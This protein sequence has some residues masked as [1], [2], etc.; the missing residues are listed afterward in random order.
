MIGKGA[1]NIS[2][3][4]LG[5]NAVSKIYLGEELVFG[6]GPQY[7]YVVHSAS[8]LIER[9]IAEPHFNLYSLVS[10]GYNYEGYS[11]SI[12]VDDNYAG[13]YALALKNGTFET[14]YPN[15]QWVDDKLQDI[16]FVAWDG[17]TLTAT[18]RDGT[19]TRHGTRTTYIS[20]ERA[21]D[22]TPV[23]GAVYYLI[24]DDASKY[25]KTLLAMFSASKDE[26][27]AYNAFGIFF[28]VST[29]IYQ[30]ITIKIDGV[31]ES[32]RLGSTFTITTRINGTQTNYQLKQ[33]NVGYR[34]YCLNN[35]SLVYGKGLYEQFA[36]YTNHAVKVVVTT[37]DGMEIVRY[38]AF[39][40]GDRTDGSLLW[41]TPVEYLESTGT[42]YIDLPMDVASGTFFEVDMTFI[43]KYTN[44][45]RYSVFSAKPYQQFEG[46]F[47][48]L[49]AQNAIT[50]ASTIGSK[51]TSGEWGGVV[52]EKT[53]YILST[54][55]KT[56]N[57][58]VYTE[59]L[60]PLTATIT[61]FRIFGSY[62][63]TSRY[64]IAFVNYKITAGTQVLYD[65]TPVK[66]GTIGY[67]FDLVESN[68]YANA[69]TGDFVLPT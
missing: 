29:N 68:L 4:Y 23:G 37:M 61:A 66:I 16:N 48:S 32:A 26:N 57:Q 31:E 39:S 33:A 38:L 49:N 28:P 34:F 24:E 60:R 6:G 40:V 45:S 42:Q 46:Q 47:Y 1:E 7:F 18:G 5:S 15:V 27:G 43:P 36:E 59:L 12:G 21:D 55:G 3:I 63:N 35:P 41:S 67:M 64:P 65:L 19:K 20:T 13:D 54:T 51:S 30:A 62:R 69:G 53:H 14:D 52:G 2:K 22:M 44:T 56:N 8:G 11:L 9:H 58:G 25:K 50:Y 17:T 10:D